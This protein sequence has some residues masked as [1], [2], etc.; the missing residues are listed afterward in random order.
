M[1]TYKVTVDEHGNIFWYLNGKRHR[2]D[3]PAVEWING[4]K[5]WYL[6]GKP[7]REDGP[8]AEFA[9]GSKE[10]YRNDRRHR[11]DGPA[12]EWADGRK[13]WYLNGVW[14]TKENHARAMS[15]VK[16]LSVAEIEKILG[17]RVKIIKE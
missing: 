5:W 10:W 9:D 7:H 13:F 17:Y 2:E 3:G 16:E 1:I 12:I 15:P 4:S 14:M 11:E 6:N 8:A